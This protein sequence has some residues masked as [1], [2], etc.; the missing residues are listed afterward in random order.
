MNWE[1]PLNVVFFN[2]IINV[3][4]GDIELLVVYI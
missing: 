2:N 3:L 4:K 1:A